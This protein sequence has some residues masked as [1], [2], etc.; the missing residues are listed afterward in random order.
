MTLAAAKVVVA[1][2][3]KIQ[4]SSSNQL[5]VQFQQEIELIEKEFS[6]KSYWHLS[7]PKV[8]LH[9]I[10]SRT[11][12][13]HNKNIFLFNRLLLNFSFMFRLSIEC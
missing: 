2:Q 11:L 10:E 3:M 6:E 8:Y 9:Q 1:E 5:S 4:G 7:Q 12:F 13:F